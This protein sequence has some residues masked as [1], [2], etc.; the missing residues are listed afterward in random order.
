M[1][2]RGKN[3]LLDFKNMNTKYILFWDNG[4][5]LK[6]HQNVTLTLALNIVQMED[7]FRIYLFTDIRRSSSR[8]PT[9]RRRFLELKN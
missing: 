8:K 5:G 2:L 4:N 7:C 3:A 1:I 6:G 9:C